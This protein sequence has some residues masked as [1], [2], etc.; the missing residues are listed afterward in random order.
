MF[1][2]KH[3]EKVVLSAHIRRSIFALVAV[4]VS[5]CLWGSLLPIFG[6]I[7]FIEFFSDKPFTDRCF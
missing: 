2:W 3:L 5:L 1:Y 6:R 4:S 7:V